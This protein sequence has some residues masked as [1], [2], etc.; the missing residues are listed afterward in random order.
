M[1][2][3]EQGLEY[4]GRPGYPCAVT[5]IDRLQ[6]RLYAIV[7]ATDADDRASRAFI[8]GITALILFSVVSVIL[9]SV[10]ALDVS[11]KSF[12]AILFA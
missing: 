5:A 12:R 1:I 11:A 6:K 3:L 10:A 2:I 7:E 4:F 8:I 9:E